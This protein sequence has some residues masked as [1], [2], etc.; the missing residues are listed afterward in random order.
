MPEHDTR[1]RDVVIVG[2]GPSGSAV[3]TILAR[4]GLDVEILERE[5]FP[6]YR[7]GESLIPYS[8][9]SLERLGVLD[10]MKSASFAIEKKSVQFASTDG[11]HVTPFYFSSHTDHDCART[12]QI[13]R[14]E[15]DRMLVDHAVEQ[16]ASVRFETSVRDLVTEGERIVGVRTDDGE[17]RARLTVDASGRD[18]FAVNR[19]DWRTP[20]PTLRKI[21]VW[22]YFK[23]ARRDMG[24]DE[25]ATTIAYLPDKGWFWFIPLADDLA[26]VG[27]VADRAY[28]YRDL[29]QRDPE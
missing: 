22:S 2:A 6:R 9:F 27:V 14:D 11:T 8:W 7:V 3:A 19:L 20:D 17:I 29:Q 5:A 16:G 4:A 12:W 15:F 13:R 28:L 24:D 21:A 23:G 25:G 10:R 26:S 1:T 18:L